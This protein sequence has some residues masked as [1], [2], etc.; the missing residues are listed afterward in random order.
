MTNMIEKL[1]SGDAV[2]VYVN[3]VPQ[4]SG[5]LVGPVIALL[6]AGLA[7]A[8]TEPDWDGYPRLGGTYFA[9]AFRLQVD[10]PGG[11]DWGTTPRVA[12]AHNKE[13]VH[14]DVDYAGSI[15]RFAIDTGG[16]LWVMRDGV[17]FVEQSKLLTR[18]GRLRKAGRD[19]LAR[20]VVSV[21]DLVKPP[22]VIA[23]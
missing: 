10:F 13:G 2:G 7:R 5:E 4:A 9:M 1:A 14:I 19:L 6:D 8:A 22:M 23:L 18:A 16:V 17:R 3:N 15:D 21:W 11:K 20:E 12:F